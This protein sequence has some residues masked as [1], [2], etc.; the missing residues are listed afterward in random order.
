[1]PTVFEE[2]YPI[3]TWWVKEHGWIEIGQDEA[4][5][6]F[7]RALDEGGMVWEGKERYATLD[8]AWQDLEAGLA[9]WA[10]QGDG[11]T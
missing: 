8:E 4:S 11:D 1:M 9:E 3:I 10:K 5:R 7:A 2:T 6:S